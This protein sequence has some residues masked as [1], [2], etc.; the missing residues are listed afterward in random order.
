MTSNEDSI[1]VHGIIIQVLPDMMYRV[2]LPNGHVV[3]AHLSAKL[4]KD[5]VHPGISDRVQLEMTPFDL[6]KGRIIAIQVSACS[7]STP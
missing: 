6:S 1:R 3:L 5:S 2:E 7:P 4:K